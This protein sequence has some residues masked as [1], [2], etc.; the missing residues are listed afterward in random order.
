MALLEHPLTS[1]SNLTVVRAG[2]REL[3]MDY[4]GLQQLSGPLL[5]RLEMIPAPRRQTIEVAF[6]LSAGKPPD[7]FLLG[8]ATVETLGFAPSV[9]GG[10]PRRVCRTHR[11][12][13][14]RGLRSS[15]RRDSR[16]SLA[17]SLLRRRTSGRAAVTDQLLAGADE[18]REHR[19]HLS[20]RV[21][22]CAWRV[23][24]PSITPP[25]RT[26]WL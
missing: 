11:R 6:G 8:L 19:E 15:G 9:F 3:G 20:W 18:I 10:D 21:A 25:R 14:A 1:A 26:T 2:A 7:R 23:A 24:E 4:A 13:I 16:R 22:G 5:D 17:G 12:E